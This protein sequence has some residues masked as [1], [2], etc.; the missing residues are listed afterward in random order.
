V[1]YIIGAIIVSGFTILVGCTGANEA[2]Q[3]QISQAVQSTIEA[4]GG[5]VVE[6]TKEIEVTR[7]VKVIQ[8]V[9]VVET[10][11]ITNEVKILASEIVS[12]TGVQ[13]SFGI[14]FEI[15]GDTSGL[16]FVK[17]DAINLNGDMGHAILGIVR[18]I[19][20]VRVLKGMDFTIEYYDEKGQLLN[21]KNESLYI[22]S[23]DGLLM[24]EDAS[25][26]LWG[27]VNL[28]PED[29]GQYKIEV[30]PSWK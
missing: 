17:W 2:N 8:E 30:L 7:E 22:G 4:S 3:Q 1:K 23:Q 11:V 5:K 6:V 24:G 27:G 26:E 18:N 12:V 10:V 21:R 25:F 15:A 14:P 20:P 28:Q 13:D 19:D 16:E 9:P 29:V